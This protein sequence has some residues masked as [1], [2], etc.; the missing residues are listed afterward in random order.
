MKQ[1][2]AGTG[3][4]I[5]QCL[6]TVVIVLVF[7][8]TTTEEAF[9]TER[10][11]SS[12]TVSNLIDQPFYQAVENSHQLAERFLVQLDGFALL[13]GELANTDRKSVV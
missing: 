10:K 8:F 12:S 2:I 1:P 3:G 4:L 11:R 5:L 6:L 13:P 7:S 9:S